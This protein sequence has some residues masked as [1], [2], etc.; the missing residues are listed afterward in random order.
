M[1]LWAA[2]ILNSGWQSKNVCALG[3]VGERLHIMAK[4]QTLQFIKGVLRSSYADL[5][6]LSWLASVWCAR[7]W[8]QGAHTANS[9]I[10]SL[11]YGFLQRDQCSHLWSLYSYQ[12]WL[13]SNTLL[14]A[15]CWPV[16]KINAYYPVAFDWCHPFISWYKSHSDLS[17]NVSTWTWIL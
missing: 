15:L 5:I 17:E 9:G 12:I 11:A 14:E 8:L 6:G 4:P 2:S 16:S 3:G 10:T 13:L 7:H 1:K